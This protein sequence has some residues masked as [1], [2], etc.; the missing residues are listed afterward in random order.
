M[1]YPY[2]W[3]HPYR[4]HIERE[5]GPLRFGQ[6]GSDVGLKASGAYGMGW[7]CR[8]RERW[9]LVAPYVFVKQ[10]LRQAGSPPKKRWCGSKTWSTWIVW[11]MTCFVLFNEV[12]LWRLQLFVSE[13][14]YSYTPVISSIEMEHLPFVCISCWKRWLRI[15]MLVCRRVYQTHQ[16]MLFF[17][18]TLRFEADGKLWID[19]IR[20]MEWWHFSWETWNL[21]DDIFLHVQMKRKNHQNFWGHL[22]RCL[23]PYNPWDWYIYLHLADFYGKCR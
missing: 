4:K 2:F 3:K 19:R 12:I 17:S 18:K 1:G 11:L 14:E 8:R 7:R 13:G 20:N 23:H 6:E 5:L 9:S 15:A 22:P 16:Y 21:R 10:N